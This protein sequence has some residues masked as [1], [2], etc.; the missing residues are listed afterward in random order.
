M[1]FVTENSLNCE[2]K[3]HMVMEIV[4][5]KLWR[6][7]LHHNNLWLNFCFVTHLFAS[8]ALCDGRCDGQ[9]GIVTEVVTEIVT[10]MSVT[11]LQGGNFVKVVGKIVT[12]RENCDGPHHKLW[13][14]PVTIFRY[15][16]KLRRNIVTDV[17]HNLGLSR[18]SVTNSVTIFWK[19]KKIVETFAAFWLTSNVHCPNN[20]EENWNRCT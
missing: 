10:A 2:G 14:R 5:D 13:Q 16:G 15:N 4:T 9:F 18:N 6:K 12:D 19:R 11:I 7:R 20:C 3:V 17:R 1:E 8:Q